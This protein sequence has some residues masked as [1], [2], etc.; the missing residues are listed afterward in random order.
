MN[1]FPKKCFCFVHFLCSFT[2]LSL[3]RCSWSRR[4]LVLIYLNLTSFN[5]ETLQQFNSFLIRF[6]HDPS[7]KVL[8]LTSLFLCDAFIKL[9]L[10]RFSLS[11]SPFSALRTILLWPGNFLSFPVKK[12]FLGM[13]KKV[14]VLE[15]LSHFFSSYLRFPAS[16]SSSLPNL[17]DTL[18][19][20]RSFLIQ[21]FILRQAST[22]INP[23]YWN[24][25]IQPTQILYA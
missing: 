5:F 24:H 19:P 4:L 14:F 18:R 11:L 7:E 3:L 15:H 1:Q 22:Q 17:T 25:K 13:D 10:Q 2:H 12:I 16:Y 23:K 20:A 9:A 8:T 21:L 6:L